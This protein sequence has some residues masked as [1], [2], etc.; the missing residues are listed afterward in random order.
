M[1]DATP[2]K[3][4]QTPAPL[5]LI[6][7]GASTGG[8]RILP[9]ILQRLKPL[10]AC[11]LIVQ[12]MPEFINISFVKTLGIHC[13]MPVR[14]AN[15]GDLLQN[16]NVLVAPG[17]IH[18][19]VTQNK[20]IRLWN[21]EKVNFVCPSIDVTMQSMQ[22]PVSGETL[23]GIILTG[24]GRDGAAGIIH[25]KK[26]GGRTIAQDRASSA[27]YGMPDE[28]ARTGCVDLILNPAEISLQL[29]RLFA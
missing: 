15:N 16:G 1:S 3:P 19:S 13:C 23:T 25:M 8:T 4:P 18:C 20:T 17:G 22:A 21:G 2:D 9:V 12:H 14:L 29:N 26:L 10:K 7:I 27:I 6:I 24:M 5:N 28:A 11:I